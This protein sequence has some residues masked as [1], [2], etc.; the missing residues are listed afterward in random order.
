MLT[1][2]TVPLA[3]ANQIDFEDANIKTTSIDTAAKNI[4][5]DTIIVKWQ[6]DTP[7]SIVGIADLGAS[8]DK[9]QAR[10]LLQTSE[11]KKE[12]VL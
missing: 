8:M 2:A 1:Y 5:G 11:W 4:A 7:A 3:N 9:T 12:G 6:G 10:A